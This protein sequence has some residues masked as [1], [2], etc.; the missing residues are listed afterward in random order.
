MTKGDGTVHE[1]NITSVLAYFLDPYED[2]GL[3][4]AFFNEFLD[5]LLKYLPETEE[6]SSL[7][8]DQKQKKG[9]NKS[10]DFATSNN[11]EVG[12]QAEVTL[13][14]DK[15]KNDGSDNGRRD[16]D[17]LLTIKNLIKEQSYS[18]LIENKI[19][20]SALQKGKKNEKSKQLEDIIK[21]ST[22]N[23]NDII[24]TN[25]YFVVL[26]PFI[27][28]TIEG[29]IPDLFIKMTYEK[30]I[31][32]V[33]EEILKKEN[34]GDINPINEF[35]K[36]I[37]KSFKMFINNDFT[38]NEYFNFSKVKQIEVLHNDAL[39]GDLEGKKLIDIVMK[40]VTHILKKKNANEID[41]LSGMKLGTYKF[42]LKKDVYEAQFEDSVSKYK[43]KYNKSEDDLAVIKFRN[44][45]RYKP[46]KYDDYYVCNQLTA[47][48]KTGKLPNIIGLLKEL[49][50]LLNNGQVKIK[51]IDDNDT[52]FIL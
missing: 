34:T 4:A 32:A 28:E 52:E 29:Q 10:I 21:L 2:H 15:K 41:A 39:F 51:I 37:L 25:P 12:V 7:R 13:S 6:L 46:L 20:I 17:I 16:I 35:S 27:N 26:L 42:L 24:F 18:I 43:N 50:Q 44:T 40:C 45:K 49:K 47:T 48:D 23:D 3:G 19:K 14:D 36:F 30:N 8:E 9:K 31:I 38:F 33:I 1:P 22:K 5:E 11:F